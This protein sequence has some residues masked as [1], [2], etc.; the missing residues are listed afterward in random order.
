MTT[1]FR[2]TETF[3]KLTYADNQLS[4]ST[5][6]IYLSI[7][8]QEL[9]LSKDMLLALAPK[10]LEAFGVT[11][12]KCKALLESDGKV[13]VSN[14]I[15]SLALSFKHNSG[16]FDIEY[17]LNE[18]GNLNCKFDGNID[19]KII[20]YLSDLRTLINQLTEGE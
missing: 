1:N 19:F 5:N 8:P 2:Q 13:F 11:E 9:A 16:R 18:E 20:N 6:G 14:F 3:V 12:G 4:I 10:M 7:N 17:T 15:D